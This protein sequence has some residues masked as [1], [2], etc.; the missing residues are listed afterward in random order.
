[1]F[2]RLSTT[3]TK[4]WGV[5]MQQLTSFFDQPSLFEGS[6]SSQASSSAASAFRLQCSMVEI[7]SE[8]L[9]G[10]SM[11]R[12]AGTF[13]NGKSGTAE[14]ANSITGLLAKSFV[15]RYHSALSLA[16][17]TVK[18]SVVLASDDSDVKKVKQPINSAVIAELTMTL[19]SYV[20]TLVKN[21]DELYFEY[22]SVGLNRI[23][24]PTIAVSIFLDLYIPQLDTFSRSY[25]VGQPEDLEVTLSLYKAVQCLQTKCEQVDYRFVQLFKTLGQKINAWVQNA[26]K[27]DNQV[28]LGTSSSFLDIF[29]SFHQQVEFLAKLK[30]PD[31]DEEAEFSNK[32][33]QVRTSSKTFITNVK[34]IG[35]GIET[36]AVAMKKLIIRD[37]A[38]QNKAA[39]PLQQSAT[40]FLKVPSSG[41][42]GKAPKKFKM[43]MP[44]M[45]KYRPPV[46]P[47]ELRLSAVACVKLVNIDATV[48]RLRDLVQSL[49][50]RRLKEVEKSL[51]PPPPPPKTSEPNAAPAPPEALR[52]RSP[53]A[54][55]PVDNTSLEAL[56]MPA[57]VTVVAAH[58]IAIVRPFTALISVRL[59]SNIPTQHLL[60]SPT[61][62][63][64]S[65]IGGPGSA[66]KKSI[67]RELLRTPR[68][69]QRPN[70]VW[71]F[72]APVI[73][74]PWELERGI[75][76]SLIQTVPGNPNDYV[77]AMGNVGMG[78]AD[79][80]LGGGSVR[81]KVEADWEATAAVVQGR[82]GYVSE[83]EVK[84][85][86]DLMVD[87]MF[88][89]LRVHL[90]DLSAK[91]KKSEMMKTK[92]VTMSK[93]T[94]TFFNNL[95]E[96]L[97]SKS[98][99]LAATSSQSLRASSSSSSLHHQLT[100]EV[101]HGDISG[102]LDHLDANLGVMAETTPE[103]ITKR[104]ASAMWDRIIAVC[105]SLL[106]PPL[107]DGE[108]VEG[109]VVAFGTEDSASAKKKNVWDETRVDFLKMTVEVL[110][111]FLHSD[112]DGLPLELLDT[113]AYRNLI[114]VFEH[115][116]LS[117][118]EAIALHERMFGTSRDS[119]ADDSWLLRLIRLRKGNDYVEK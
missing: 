55:V 95:G 114:N 47:A 28:E 104:F 30:W 22:E 68:K 106:M 37:L 117:R 21:Y 118:D 112:G 19:T 44:G 62:E 71:A 97:Q 92:L 38:E 27:L 8:V 82:V 102:L 69:P 56:G 91:Y 60:A 64:P 73:I 89:D 14:L 46:D 74:K 7:M 108:I 18:A 16:E 10:V 103:W 43:Y 101:V 116:D 58:K 100:Y 1:M 3:C 107:G 70:I 2:E 76:I 42:D 26:I 111:S 93:N 67:V 54:P 9:S 48:D 25:G 99:T 96:K 88:H 59:S 4:L 63:L 105:A 41:V 23:H 6:P 39:K 29:T 86:V 113:P 15:G 20:S 13:Q 45:R 51:P 79:V 80:P 90:K 109:A 24:I 115:Y 57:R 50:A 75:D 36:Y 110:K 65:S 5:L 72:T 61:D 34:N 66:P 98:Q 53:F 35:E 52:I 81:V 17:A 11:Q 85:A 12:E 31:A 83:R 94:M 40:S 32:L 78:E 84:E 49:P 77:V 33:L 119:D 87:K